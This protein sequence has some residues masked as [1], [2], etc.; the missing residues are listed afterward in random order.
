MAACSVMVFSFNLSRTRS[1]SSRA[2]GR[3]VQPISRISS[4]RVSPDR[5]LTRSIVI[6]RFK[7]PFGSRTG[8]TPNRR[9]I[10]VPNSFRSPRE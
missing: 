8:S 2:S 1:Q 7:T 3:S 10:L 4:R 9:I 6:A 5:G